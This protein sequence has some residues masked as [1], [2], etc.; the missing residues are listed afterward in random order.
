MQARMF[1]LSRFVAWSSL[2]V[3]YLLA[4]PLS[5]LFGPWLLPGGALADSV[6]HLTGVGP[7]RGIGF[8]LIVLSAALLVAVAAS[9]ANPRLRGIEDEMADEPVPPATAE[10]A[11]EVDA[12]A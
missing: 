5:D 7:G 8:L 6:G 2:P 9:F 11:P 1:A 12:R 10:T 4:G 3:A